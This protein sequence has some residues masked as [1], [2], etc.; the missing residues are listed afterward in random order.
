MILLGE[1]ADI[2][3]GYNIMRLSEEDQE[4]KYSNADFEHDFYRM[5]LASPSNDI[6][7]RQSVAA[8]N[9]SATIISDENKG[10]FISQVFSIMKI[11]R[12]KL[13]PWYLCYLLNES[14]IVAKQCNVLLQGSV[15][16]RLSAHQL[17]QMQIPVIPM[18]EQEKL[19]MLYSTTLYQYYLETTRATMKLQGI[20]S[21]LHDRERK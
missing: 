1:V 12:E 4:R 3:S 2:V 19:G 18:A 7:Y 5:K 6:I 14:D 13:N 16:T 17:K 20:L 11:D 8:H 21:I 10:K 15:I 9:M